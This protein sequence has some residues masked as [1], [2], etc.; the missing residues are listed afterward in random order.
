M[1]G[2]TVRHVNCNYEGW[3]L[4]FMP[5]NKLLSDWLNPHMT[6]NHSQWVVVSSLCNESM[7]GSKI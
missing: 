6:E 1:K 5:R 7:S 4:V 3:E 2:K